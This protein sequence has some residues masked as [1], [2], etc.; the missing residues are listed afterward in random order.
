MD[1][2]AREEFLAGVH[3][4]VLSAAPGAPGRTLAVPVWY[5]YRPGGL[6]TVLTGRGSRK[7][8]AIRAAGRFS[9]CAQD[10]HPPY[11]YVS[12]EGPVVSE[13]KPSA[14]GRLAL[15][16]RYLG[17]AG[18]DAYVTDNPDPGR[19][20]MAFRIRPE[21]WLSQDQG[22]GLAARLPAR[23]ARKTA[24]GPGHTLTRSRMRPARPANPPPIA[25]Y[26]RIFA[27]SIRGSRLVDR[28]QIDLFGVPHVPGSRRQSLARAN[29]PQRSFRPPV[30]RRPAAVT[31][32]PD[33]RSMPA[34]D[35]GGN[36]SPDSGNDGV[37]CSL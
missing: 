36:W 9:L 22:T 26:R 12:V 4:G 25:P 31:Q 28:V 33:H 3:V 6:V 17:T 20:N 16:R 8:Q 15:A 19:E 10:E 23:P 30:S 35:A 7:T 34:N 27:S 24:R 21:H 5:D 37:S 2:A 13:E 18:G 1:A 32:L 29:G 14:A 11:R